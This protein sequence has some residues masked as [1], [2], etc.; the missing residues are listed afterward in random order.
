MSFSVMDRVRLDSGA[1]CSE[2]LRE[3]I[4]RRLVELRLARMQYV[5]G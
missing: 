1:D 2:L 5:G 3:E 4:Y